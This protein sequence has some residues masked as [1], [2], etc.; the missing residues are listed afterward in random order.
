VV[1]SFW[2]VC[3]VPKIPFFMDSKNYWG[4]LGVGLTVI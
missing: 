4:N 1:F 2:R 3:N